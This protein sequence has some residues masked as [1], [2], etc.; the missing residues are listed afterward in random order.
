VKIV[1][2]EFVKGIR[3]TDAVAVDG[4]PQ[5]AFV[6]RSNVGKSS[7][8]AALT[9]N[10]ALVKVSNTPGKTREINFFRIN[11]KHYLVDL[12]GYGYARV[13]PEEKEKLQKLLLWY[14]T[15][16]SIRPRIVVI[17]L[18]VKVGIT[19]FD[20]QMMQ[21]LREQGH[22]FIIAANKIDKLTKKELAQQFSKIVAAA[23]GAEVLPVS[24][25]K[26]EGVKELASMLFV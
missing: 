17:V 21:I 2:A 7:L 12:P 3:G 9:H 11:N 5:V 25:A 15:D 18:D 13:S 14:F 19:E 6:G 1:S 20:R 10:R 22:P 4:T 23:Q 8:I 16:T 26:Q 24:A